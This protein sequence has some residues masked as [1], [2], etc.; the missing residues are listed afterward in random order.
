M[1]LIQ[2][3]LLVKYMYIPPTITTNIHLITNTITKITIKYINQLLY[4]SFL[5]Y[6]Y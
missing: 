3:N 4:T 5:D 1:I 2:S 6:F